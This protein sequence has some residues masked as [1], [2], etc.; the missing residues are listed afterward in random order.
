[1]PATPQYTTNPLLSYPSA[2]DSVSVTPSGTAWSN[3]AWVEIVSAASAD[4][5]LTGI[6]IR[7]SS[8]ESVWVEID[9]GV[10][11]AGA[12]AVIDTYKIFNNGQNFS[13]NTIGGSFVQRGIPVDAIPSGARVAIRIRTS[14][15]ALTTWQ[16]G[17]VLLQKPIVG[18]LLTSGQPTK[19]TEP[20]AVPSTINYNNNSWTNSSWVQIIASTAAAIVI[21]GLG[22]QTGAN[23]QT[24]IDVG[25]GASGSEVVV[26]TYRFTSDGSVPGICYLPIFNP[27]DNVGSGVRVALRARSNQTSS[28]ARLFLAYKEKPL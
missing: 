21:E 27:L 7:S 11:A 12:E 3:S 20:A 9:I 25:V 4:S 22:G 16:I 14:T 24:A 5:V 10:G 2:A 8:T 15:T 13:T 28:F 6:T 23:Q 1:M 17:I 26:G 19:V 18:T